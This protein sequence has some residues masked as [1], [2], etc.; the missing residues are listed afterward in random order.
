MKINELI[1][2]LRCMA[3]EPINEE[4]TV[5]V[6]KVGDGE[7]ETARVGVAMFA[8]P[9][10]VRAAVEYG[11]NFLIVHEPLFYTHR[12]TEMPFAQCFEKKALLEQSGLTVFRFHDYAH[13]M[14]PDLIYEGQIRF[15]GLC[16]HFEKGKYFAVNRFVLDRE[17]TTLELARAL[18]EGLGVRHLRIV[19][20]RSNTVKTVSCCFGTPGHIMEEIDE[21]DTLLTGEIC[22]W[23]MGEYVRDGVQMGKKKSMI[24]MGH[25][26]SEKFGMRLLADKLAALYPQIGVKY[27]DCGDVY[28][29]TDDN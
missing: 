11:A 25:I 17:M 10:V 4:K 14:L 15:S 24:V 3:A 28:S 12:D 29:Y 13:A 2:A 19:G 16:G 22:E 18:E 1:S 23:S 9:E 6:I 21:C 5:D 20:D 27:F 7:Q 26:N 8:T